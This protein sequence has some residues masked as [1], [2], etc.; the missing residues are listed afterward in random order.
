MNE[1]PRFGPIEER[2]QAEAERLL[3]AGGAPTGELLRAEWRRR[4][5]VPRR[6][7][8]ATAVLLAAVVAMVAT[9]RQLAPLP[10]HK[11]PERP[12]AANEASGVRHQVSGAPHKQ[13]ERLAVDD[14]S[15][16][17][18]LVV[19]FVVD[20]P[21]SGKPLFSGFYVPEQVEPIDLRQLPR[22][23]RDAIREVLGIEDT[24]RFEPL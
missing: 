14:S 20:D 22:A 2:L 16:D 3:I 9:R 23:E 8:A 17:T 10:P 7:A 11:Q 4:R 18:L 13:P 12:V 1:D 24:A 21:A 19:P 6:I 5:A 15:G